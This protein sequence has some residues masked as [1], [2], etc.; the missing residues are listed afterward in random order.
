MRVI[1]M[2]TPDF[3]LP[4][5]ESLAAKHS[6]A[7]VVASP[8]R[9][10][11]R[12]LQVRRPPVAQAAARMGVPILQPQSARDQE[13]GEAVRRSG[14]DVVV[15]AAFGQILTAELLESTPLGAVNVHASLLP[16][17]RGA[18]PVAAAILAGDN[19]TGVSIM[20]MDEG[21]D[22]G[23]VLL[24][25]RMRLRGDETTGSLT[26][27][28]AEVGATALMEAL[29][30][31]AA[32]RLQPTPQAE[33]G[34]TYAPRVRKEDGDWEW[35]H[36]ATEIE[37]A[38]RAYDPWPGL[39]LPLGGERPRLLRG[40]PMPAW[41]GGPAAHGS[42]GSVIEVDQ[43]GILLMAADAPFLV[44]E[45]QPAGRRPMSAAAFARGRRG[46]AGKTS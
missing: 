1:F 33:E 23:P 29:D 10:A 27:R 20:Q 19:E 13:L 25:Q 24:Q 5:L 22:T 4:S 40:T 39:R 21:L 28:L 42:P 3:A 16:R 35:D 37:R 46:L 43:R 17:W 14:A 36:A 15:V 44:E 7:L 9:P 8:D 41:T 30:L 34:V 2:G 26:G 18:S 6:L 32:R 45:V 11:G 31:I 38:A 12:G